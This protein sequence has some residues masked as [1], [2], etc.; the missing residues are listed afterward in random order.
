M[1]DLIPLKKIS[2]ILGYSEEHTRR[3]IRCGYKLQGFKIGIVWAA[4]AEQVEDFIELKKAVQPELNKL[5]ESEK[6]KSANEGGRYA[7]TVNIWKAVR[8]EIEQARRDGDSQ[9][10]LSL[11]K[12]C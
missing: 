4:T 12:D 2:E 7:M 9:P 5:R 3:L 11:L 8:E 1:T 10:Q 6:Y